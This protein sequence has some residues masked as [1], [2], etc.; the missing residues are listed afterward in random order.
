MRMR[1]TSFM[2]AMGVFFCALDDSVD[3]DDAMTNDYAMREAE[4]VTDPE[5]NL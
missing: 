5:T 2:I 3:T 4:N 1:G